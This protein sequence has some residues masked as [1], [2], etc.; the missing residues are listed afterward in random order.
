MQPVEQL[1]KDLVTINR[2]KDI[3]RALQQDAANYL[4]RRREKILNSRDYFREAWKVYGILRRFVNE[5]PDLIRKKLVVLA[6]PNQGIYGRLLNKAIEKAKQIYFQEKADI[7]ITGRKGQGSFANVQE[8]SRY[9][10]ELDPDAS[11]EDIVPIKK[12]VAR[13]S[14]VIIVY[15]TYISI[16]KQEVAVAT[17]KPDKEGEREGENVSPKNYIIEPDV[18]K[19]V[20]YFN[21]LLSGVIFYSY[22]AESMLA[23]K[24]AEMILMEN[25]HSNAEDLEKK[26][27]IKLFKVQREIK[28]AKLRDLFLGRRRQNA[29][30]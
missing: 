10:F 21:Q 1:K 24:A 17:F 11:Y 27:Q 9:F 20:N 26:Q 25:G 5:S 15:A 13:Y 16:A 29:S 22:F 19:V 8:G 4:R 6:N 23:F 7:L 28:D 30:R 12:I 18:K 14:Q 3:T 2:L